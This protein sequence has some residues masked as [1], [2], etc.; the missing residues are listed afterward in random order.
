MYHP[1]IE[2]L[3]HFFVHA[4]DMIIESTNKVWTLEDDL[5]PFLQKEKIEAKERELAEQA[6][7]RGEKPVPP[8]GPAEQAADQDGDKYKVAN[9]ALDHDF[10]WIVEAKEELTK[11]FKDNI[12]KPLELLAQY[13]EYEYILNVDAKKLI[14]DLFE[15][16]EIV[17]VEAVEAKEG[18]EA[19]EAVEGRPAGKV[20]IDEIRK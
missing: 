18:R 16:K 7:A 14:K 2:K 9:F 6:E 19:V 12:V 4:L 13:K 17:A 8:K 15:A 10:D 3:E 20:S 1:K 11:R 5:M